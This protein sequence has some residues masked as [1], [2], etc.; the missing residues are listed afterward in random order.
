MVYPVVRA[1]FLLDWSPKATADFCGFV[2][3]FFTIS[4]KNFLHNM[5]NRVRDAKKEGL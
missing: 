2:K 3:C 1:T 4:S 5:Q